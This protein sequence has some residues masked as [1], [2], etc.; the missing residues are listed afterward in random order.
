MQPMIVDHPLIQHKISLLR[1]KRTGTKEFRDLVSEIAMLL[2]YE[3]TR[4]LPTE[5]VEIETPVAMAKTKV[6]A[7]RKLALVPILRAGMGMLDGMLSLIPAAKVG[8][9]GLYRDEKTLQPVE[10]FCKLPTDIAERDVLVLDPMLATGGSA[11]DAITQIKKHGAK[12]IKFIGLIAAPEGIAALHKAHPD[13]DIF[14][15]ALDDHLNENGYI[16]PGLGD[17][18]DRIYGTK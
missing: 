11:T 16:V 12:K 2:C 5:E 15:A 3:A 9:I 18:G 17:A 6:L 1:N 4:D 8:F 10:Y 13:V 7:G 14:V